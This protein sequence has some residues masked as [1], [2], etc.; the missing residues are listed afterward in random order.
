MCVFRK[1]S[2][3][4]L[5]YILYLLS[6]QLSGY[7]QRENAKNEYVKNKNAINKYNTNHLKV[8]LED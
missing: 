6:F 4:I 2:F 1:R 7:K 5:V 8:N 3:E